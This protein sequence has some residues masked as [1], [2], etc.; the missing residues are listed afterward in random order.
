MGKVPIAFDLDDSLNSVFIL[1]SGE[2]VVYEYDLSTYEEISQVSLNMPESMDY[3]RFPFFKK[4]HE[5]NIFVVGTGYRNYKNEWDFYKN[6]KVLSVFGI[7][8]L[9]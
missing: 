9:V 8:W 4:V 6:S 7:D 3:L 5:Q 1:F 2:Y